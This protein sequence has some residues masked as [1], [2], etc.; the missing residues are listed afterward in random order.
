MFFLPLP[1]W[2]AIIIYAQPLTK[3]L[4]KFNSYLN[5]PSFIPSKD[6]IYENLFTFLGK[7]IYIWWT[8]G[9]V[10]FYYTPPPLTPNRQ[11]CIIM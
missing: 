6:K 5:K 9:K 4:E 8:L 7:L 11:R 3:K 1:L 2:W 10:N